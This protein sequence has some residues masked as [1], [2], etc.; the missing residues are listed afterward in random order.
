MQKEDIGP[1]LA[2]A[3]RQARREWHQKNKEALRTDLNSMMPSQRYHRARHFAYSVQ[4]MIDKFV[5][6]ACTQD[7]IEELM[8]YAY[9][10]DIEI[11][12]VPPE[13]DAAV[14]AAL[15]AAEVTLPKYITPKE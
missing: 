11:V 6:E 13:R 2:I 7:A 3:E 9:G 8:V 14:A 10:H 4:S 12:Q 15:K 1:I 5:P